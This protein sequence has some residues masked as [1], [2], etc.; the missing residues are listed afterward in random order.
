MLAGCSQSKVGAKRN[1]ITRA[2]QFIRKSY[3]LLV[4]TYGLFPI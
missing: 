1:R 2:S 4:W 3:V